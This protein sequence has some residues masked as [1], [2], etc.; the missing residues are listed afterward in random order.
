MK[1]KLL[2]LRRYVD[3]LKIAVVVGAMR[4]THGVLRTLVSSEMSFAD[5]L[6][7]AY[8]YTTGRTRS[9]IDVHVT[10]TEYENNAI[11]K[12]SSINH[13]LRSRENGCTLLIYYWL[14]LADNN[15]IVYEE[16]FYF[17]FS[18]IIRKILSAILL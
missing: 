7:T 12:L 13:K 11:T 4:A 17:N 6:L 2:D 16:Y 9:N 8:T 14:R 18:S 10:E 1:V 3:Y 5:V 15:E